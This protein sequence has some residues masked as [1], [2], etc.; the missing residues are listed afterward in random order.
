MKISEIVSKSPIDHVE[1]EIILAD[2][3]KKDRSFLHAHPDHKPSKNQTFQFINRLKR[4][5]KNEPLAYILGYRE[6]YGFKFFVDKRVMIPR[7]D[8]EELIYAVI[9]CAKKEN[10]KPIKI[11]D[12]GTGSGCIAITLAKLLTNAKIY[13]V[14]IDQKALFVARKNAKHHQVY[15]KITF[16]KSNL[17][18]SLPEPVDVIVANLPYIK[19]AKIKRLEPEVY[20]WEPKL[21]LDGGA[22]G[23]KEYDKLFLQASKYL[24][25]DGKIIYETDGKVFSKSPSDLPHS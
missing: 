23:K 15:E 8:T 3:L 20:N 6:F 4:R 22:D 5:E 7:H 10:K 25:R 14:D 24:R 2:I 13:A 1:T 12:V 11:V 17:L 16:L 21:A 9:K 18:S 19:T